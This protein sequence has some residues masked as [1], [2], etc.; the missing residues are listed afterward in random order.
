MS[1][2]RGQKFLSLLADTKHELPFSPRLLQRLFT[3]TSE[4]SVASL[5]EIAAT[6][7]PDQGLTT[8]ILAVSNSAF[9]GLQ[10]QVT[11]VH[12]AATV[13]GIKEVRNIVLA[14][15]VQGMTKGK[16][17]PDDFDLIEYWRHQLT[18]ALTVRLLAAETK[19]ADPDNLF[20]AGLLHDLGKMIVA[21][22]AP[23]DWKAIADLRQE[24]QMSFHKAEDAWWGIEHGVVGA[25]V[26]KSWSLPA[27][28]HEP[29]NWHHAPLAAPDYR[30]QAKHLCLADMLVNL[31]YQSNRVSEKAVDALAA[32]LAV[33]PEK[34]RELTATAANDEGI[35]HFISE[36]LH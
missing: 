33:P 34:A 31:H 9:Y 26:L 10:S 17:L 12:R 30:L 15:G 28:L 4:G 18:V 20:T 6:I 23:E 29:V 32:T 2:E 16:K 3:Q 36:V 8:R 27:E 19:Q 5:G 24:K 35:G 11:S 13:L 7:S 1:L 22:H 14:L 25:L 21:M